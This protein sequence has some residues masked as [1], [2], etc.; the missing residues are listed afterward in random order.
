MKK[1]SPPQKKPVEQQLTLQQAIQFARQQHQA[2]QFDKAKA[3]YLQILEVQANNAEVWHLLGIATAQTDQPAQA[4]EYFEK[5]INLNPYTAQYYSH[6]G[7]ALQTLDRL[8]EALNCYQTAL[9]LDDKQADIYNNLGGVYFKQHRLSEAEQNY[10]HALILNPQHIDAANNLVMVFIE[11]E[12]P[13]EAIQLCEQLKQHP[14]HRLSA[15]LNLG[16]A[17]MLKEEW[18]TALEYFTQALKMDE[19]NSST[20]FNLG[21]VYSEMQEINKAFKHYQRAIALQPNYPEA[22]NNLANLYKQQENFDQAIHYYQKSIE[23]NRH[24]AEAHNNLANVYQLQE[25]IDLALQHY[26]EALRFKPHLI[27][28]HHN[29]AR[30]LLILQRYQ[31]GWQ[32]YIWR[33]SRESQDFKAVQPASKLELL[34]EDLTGQRF[35]LQKEQGLGDE[36]F[37]LRFVP[38]LKQRGAEWIAYRPGDKLLSIL[39]RHPQLDQIVL[40][41]ESLPT[42]DYRYLLGDLPQ[43]MGVATEADVPPPFQLSVLPEQQ[44]AWQAK[45]ADLGKPP[46]IAITWRS[47]IQKSQIAR[48]FWQQTMHKEVE[49][50]ELAALLRSFDA[51]ILAVQRNPQPGEIEQLTDLLQRPVHDLTAL[52][53]DLESML[54]LLACIDDYVGVSNTNIHLLA[55]LSKTAR[56]LISE[57]QD[58]RWLLKEDYSP[59]FPGFKIYRRDRITGWQ[60]CLAQLHADLQIAFS[61]PSSD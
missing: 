48:K 6:L 50:S 13:E 37:F 56:I 15:T 40:A 36:I 60:D 4:I 57:P 8:E 17:Y 43:V 31:A 55:G 41:D 52:N 45:L 39:S 51:T 47:G 38:Q 61:Q 32:E 25:Q 24:Y 21:N 59:W 53:D 18:P 1:Q 7:N 28:P 12:Q 22:Y 42:V 26:D 46:Y 35:F 16:K 19:K 3:L 11:K 2:G 44:T 30:L 9:K 10:H 27:D 49:L 33:P 54:G 29:K 23:C 20:H 34:P 5:A 58:W 14:T